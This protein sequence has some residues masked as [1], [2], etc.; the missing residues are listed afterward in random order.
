MNAN[1]ALALV[2]A[3]IPED[4]IENFRL[5]DELGLVTFRL[6]SGQVVSTFTDKGKK[7]MEADKDKLMSL[8]K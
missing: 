1:I 6:E 7:F 3:K 2:A 5:M 8:I 4:V